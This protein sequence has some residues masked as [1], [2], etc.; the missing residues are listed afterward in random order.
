MV[1]PSACSVV[2]RAPLYSASYPVIGVALRVVSSDSCSLRE[3]QQVHDQ[4]PLTLRSFGQ[5]QVGLE[6][7]SGYRGSS[8]LLDASFD[9][10]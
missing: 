4:D 6:R 7:N 9:Q 2:Q 5:A 3:R 8:F 1:T 10:S